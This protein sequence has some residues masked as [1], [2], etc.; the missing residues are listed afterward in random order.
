MTRSLLGQPT[1]SRD[2]K[3]PPGTAGAEGP[4]GVGEDS[5]DGE[6]RPNELD[7]ERLTP[8][9]DG[10]ITRSRDE[11]RGDLVGLVA[12]VPTELAEVER[13]RRRRGLIRAGY[14]VEPE[15]RSVL[16]I[17]V[18]QPQHMCAVAETECWFRMLA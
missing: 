17:Q 3:L 16:D 12:N 15:V 10:P 14:Q 6:R 13:S 4:Y 9:E 18:L 11:V 1:E 7:A 8:H 5:W 2:V